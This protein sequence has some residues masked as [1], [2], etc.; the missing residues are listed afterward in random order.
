MPETLLTLGVILFLVG[1]IGQVK[2]KELELGTTNRLARF[3]IGVIGMGFISISLYFFIVPPTPKPPIS[4]PPSPQ[5]ISSET[6]TP[7][8]LQG[9][10]QV[11]QDTITSP[12]AQTTSAQDTVV[13]YFSLLNEDQYQ[14]AWNL[15]SPRF[16]QKANNNDF[17]SYKTNWEQYNSIAIEKIKP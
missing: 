3:I 13:H 10:S 12:P 11:L 5:P 7:T 9:S 8:P 1:L 4:P 17:N 6:R 2:A 14:Q 15:L 16:R